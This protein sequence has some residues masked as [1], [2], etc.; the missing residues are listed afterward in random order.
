MMSGARTSEA[1]ANLIVRPLLRADYAPAWRAMQAFT[2]QRTPAT[3]DE[4]WLIE[5][6]PVYTLGR[7][8][9]MEHL[10]RPT[11]IPVIASDRGGQITYHGPGQLVAY[12]LCDL[13][14][15]GLGVRPFVN[16]IENVVI[17]VLAGYGI[18]GSARRDAPGVYVN[19]QKIAALGLRVR[20]G[21]SYHGLS[22]NVAMDLA[23]FEAI[24]PCGY[25]GLGV[26]Q[27]TALGGPRDLAVVAD[28]LVRQFKTRAGY[29]TV[30]Y[31]APLTLDHLT[32]TTPMN[33]QATHG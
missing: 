7:S 11:D 17:D 32:P 24:N 12:L 30:R 6:P 4:L 23:P 31:T 5:H 14:R 25:P 33:P 8:A 16:L 13:S 26:T 1:V 20:R 19:A 2:D 29:A 21:C 3:P 15:L 22:L 28:A 10:L 9:K 18:T 27:I